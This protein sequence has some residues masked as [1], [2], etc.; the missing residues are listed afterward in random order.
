MYAVLAHEWTHHVQFILRVPS[1]SPQRELQADCG[2]GMFLAAAWP[3]MAPSDL[4]PLRRMLASNPSDTLHGTPAQRLAA[5]D[6]GYLRGA[7]AQCGLPI[8]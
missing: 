6:D 7:S 5:F 3:H 1:D 4:D 8:T 2:S